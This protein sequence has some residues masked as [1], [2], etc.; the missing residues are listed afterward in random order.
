MYPSVAIILCLHRPGRRRAG[1]PSV[2]SPGSAC[3]SLVFGFRLEPGRPGRYHSPPSLAVI[4]RCT[5]TLQQSGDLDVMMQVAEE[6]V[7]N[8]EPNHHPGMGPAS[9][10]SSPSPVR[11]GHVIYTMLTIIARH[12][13]QER[14]SAPDAPMTRLVGA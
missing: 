2:S 6:Q 1:S 9:P 13:H 3:W 4:P 8:I 10:G 5:A 7:V 12:R 14:T 11:T